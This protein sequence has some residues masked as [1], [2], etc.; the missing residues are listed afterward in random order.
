MSVCP[1]GWGRPSFRAKICFHRSGLPSLAWAIDH[2]V[3]W[4]TTVYVVVG[5][6]AG[7][8]GADV[9][10]VRAGAAAR[11]P[12][13]EGVVWTTSEPRTT[14]AGTSW[15]ARDCRDGTGD[16]GWGREN[17][18]TANSTA[19]TSRP[20]TGWKT[21]PTRKRREARPRA[22]ATTSAAT[23]LVALAQAS[24]ATQAR[25]S[26]NTRS[27]RPRLVSALCTAE[28]LSRW[29]G[30]GQPTTSTRPM[31]TPTTRAARATNAAAPRTTGPTAGERA[32]CGHWPAAVMPR[33]AVALAVPLTVRVWSPTMPRIWVG[34]TTRTV[35]V[36]RSPATTT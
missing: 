18:K 10:V 22:T 8:P 36:M 9:S 6:E 35:T 7:V 20:A 19:A 14:D 24:Q 4:R 27:D 30:R 15:L 1:S 23:E 2:R 25:V 16:V 32:V 28:A 11:D 13:V 5:G 17:D 26:S 3:S 34:W 21:A 12:L 29:W 33:T 31:G